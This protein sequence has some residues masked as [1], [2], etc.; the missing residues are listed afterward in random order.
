VKFTAAEIEE[1]L[2]KGFSSIYKAFGGF[3]GDAYWHRCIE[4]VRD[5]TLLGHIIFCNDVLEVPPTH[6][7][8]RARPV[9]EDLPE[10]SKRAIGAFWGYVFKFVFGYRNQKSVTAR[11]NTVRTATYFYDIA[12]PVEIVKNKNES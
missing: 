7:F 3:M 11:V 6:T 1:R 8:L 12:E 9:K 10:F 4:A 5:E 2:N